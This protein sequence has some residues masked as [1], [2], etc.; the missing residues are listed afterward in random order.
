MLNLQKGF[1]CLLI[2]VGFCSFWGLSLYTYLFPTEL[3][4]RILF[5]VGSLLIGGLGLLFVMRD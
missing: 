5:F 2:G 3:Y 4:Q 1:G